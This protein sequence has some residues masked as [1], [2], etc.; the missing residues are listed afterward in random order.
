[1]AR[2]P[3]AYGGHHRWVQSQKPDPDTNTMGVNTH[4]N[5]EARQNPPSSTY[6]LTGLLRHLTLKLTIPILL[7]C[8]QA[9][10]MGGRDAIHLLELR[11]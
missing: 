8:S 4:S 3:V 7:V 5:W 2:V 9:P 11:V 10:D 6:S 1:M